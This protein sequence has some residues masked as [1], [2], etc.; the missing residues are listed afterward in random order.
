LTGELSFVHSGARR[1]L[2]TGWLGFWLATVLA[3]PASAAN[4]PASSFIVDS[5]TTEEGLPQNSVTTV[6]Q[7]RD[8]YLWFG[9]LNGL[10]RFDG[11]KFSVFD[12]SNTLGLESGRVVKLFE[13]RHGQ[14]WIGMES[15]GVALRKPNG[16]IASFG[17][18]QGAFEKRVVSICEDAG[19]AIWLFLA[20]GELWRHSGGAWQPFL[21]GQGRPSLARSIIADNAGM[22][23][24]GV[25]WQH[26]GARAAALQQTIELPVEESLPVNGRLDFLLP[27]AGGGYW[28]LA[29]GRVQKCLGAHIE[30]D[31][32]AYPW[33]RERVSAVC[34]D[35]E[36]RLVVGTLGN[37]VFWLTEDGRA[38]HLSTTNGLSHSYVL[39]LCVDREGN[40]WVGTDGG[41]LNR[42]KQKRFAAVDP[43]GGA[44]RAVQSVFADSRG[45]LWTGLNNGGVVYWR[46]GISRAY[47]PAQGLMNPYVWSV[48][49]D[50][51][52]TV[53]AGTWGGGLYFLQGD[54]FQRTTG[55]E[56]IHREAHALFQDRQGRLWIG[57]QGG[58]AVRDR[59]Q[60][61]V[62]IPSAD[63]PP[64]VVQALAQDREDR[65]WIGTVRGGLLAWQHGQ[66]TVFRK[67][68]G[69]PGDDVSAL[70]VDDDGVLWAGS[71]GSGLGRR[72]DGRWT[73][74]TTRE[75]LPSNSI[76]YLVDDGQGFLWIGSNAGLVRLRKQ[77]A[78]DLAAGRITSLPCRVYGKAEGLPTRE[79]T[80]GS[81]PAAARAPDG[82]LWFP[83]IKGLASVNPAQL[84]SNPTPPPV[85]IEEVRVDGFLQKDLETPSSRQRALH[86]SARQER[87]EIR[88]TSL[89]LGA[90]DQARFRYRLQGH[91][92]G[93][94]EA[95][96]TRAAYYSKLPPGDYRF[97]VI[98]CN[99]DGV[100]NETGAALAIRVEPPF[101]QAWWF[102]TCAAAALLGTV[103]GVVHYLSTQRL[104]RQLQQFR[105]QEAL[106]RERARIAR[107]LHDQLG[108]SLTQISLLGELAETDKE[109]PAEVEAHARQISQTAR[110]TTRV[111]DEIV[112]A[113]NP[114]NDTLDG[115]MTYLCKYA[116]E[117]LALAGVRFRLEAPDHLPEVQL[118]PDARH[119]LFLAAKEA[120][121]NVARH[122]QATEARIRL[123]L[124][125]EYFTLEIED[126]GR[127]APA[128]A[129]Q[130]RNGLRNMRKRLEEIGGRC[131]I[132][133]ATPK[134]TRVT[135]RAPCRPAASGNE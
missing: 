17:I 119:N 102:L 24:V 28:R 5:W 63:L 101:W 2:G 33:G 114:S 1:R 64:L 115:L 74:F 50:R 129:G 9:T 100:W 118:P 98:A 85:L 135:L 128:N 122:A 124:E 57:T 4:P 66:F 31:L 72:Q 99:E 8:G 40:L 36:G 30:R 23:W 77:A 53:W 46:D 103:V 109:T 75:G 132:G 62:V 76:N 29:D 70:C 45:G 112:W 60:W 26:T 67:T 97:Q 78:A 6:L 12:E 104:Q 38:S 105:Q 7:T 121:T 22:I 90:P 126:D 21:V 25:D 130:N 10:V 123:R 59:G 48:L 27:S 37:G 13:D 79:C 68:D 20:N 87:L 32:G 94:T 14:L 16:Q 96:G 61:Q 125:P 54:R 116:Q 110:D 107:D 83:T 73:R 65:L 133:P 108:A 44:A 91:E 11:L 69:L 86:L 47:G 43:S 51:E 95:G 71:S 55:P 52:Q 93:W 56:V 42:V 39:S 127:G 120:V 15:A 117:Y 18:G 58:L 111:L 80:L 89:N 41:G 81:Q 88:Y 113:V 19:G 131:D 106:Q 34:E 134:G 35:R 92:T 82:A 84:G 3:F 49:V